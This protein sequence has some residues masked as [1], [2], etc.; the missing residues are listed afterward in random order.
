MS[1]TKTQLKNKPNKQNITKQTPAH[2]IIYVL[3][4]WWFSVG[5]LPLL[6]PYIIICGEIISAI[7]V[8]IL[9]FGLMISN[10]K[11]SVQCQLNTSHTEMAEEKKNNNKKK[12]KTTLCFEFSDYS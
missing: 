1:I 9:G 3:T 2:E 11:Y 12:N 8:K 7:N 10:I 5:W 4:V 6:F